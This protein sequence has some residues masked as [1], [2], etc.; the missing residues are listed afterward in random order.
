MTPAQ[1]AEE[2]ISNFLTLRIL[3]NWQRYEIGHKPPGPY[4]YDA[5]SCF[6]ACGFGDV[7]NTRR[8]NY[9]RLGWCRAM[10]GRG[11]DVLRNWIQQNVTDAEQHGT[12]ER[13]KALAEQCIVE[14]A[15]HSR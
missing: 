5:L 11:I 7:R 3:Y 15:A 13:A 6:G 2:S 4:L 14:A 10:S 9:S 12:R 8:H 1:A